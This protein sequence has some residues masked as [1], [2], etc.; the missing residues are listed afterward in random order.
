LELAEEMKV[1]GLSITVPYKEAVLPYLFRCSEMV[2]SI[3]ACNTM[4]S[5][6]EGWFGE[7][8][9]IGG[10][11]ESL[12]KFLDRKN[13]KRQK[14]TIIGAGGAARA[15]AAG[16]HQMG[17]KALILNRTT[18]K[19]RN[20]ASEYNF[21]WGGL[22]NQGIELMNK[23]SDIIIQTTSVGMEGSNTSDPL[24]GYTFS[25]KEAVMDLVYKPEVTPFLERAA[26]AGCRTING[27]DMLIRQACLQYACFMGREIPPQVLAR[28]NTTRG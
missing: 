14:I 20:L 18:Y 21:R 26:S 12:L 23:Y 5:I 6:K 10:F 15:V 28:V 4:S 19:S 16:V 3:G 8:T 22:D 7:N 25:G 27:Y 1:Q 9:D 13:L 24:E 17:G 11:S 2:Q